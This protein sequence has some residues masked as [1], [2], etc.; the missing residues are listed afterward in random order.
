[1]SPTHWPTRRAIRAPTTSGW[2]WSAR[3]EP[4]TSRSPCRSC[5]GSSPTTASPRSRGDTP[6]N[7][8]IRV[9]LQGDDA[10]LRDLFERSGMVEIVDT[11]PEV[12]VWSLPQDADGLPA[13]MRI[14]LADTHGPAIVALTDSHPSRWFD[15]ALALGV[16]E[17]V[18]LPQEPQSLGMAAAKARAMRSRRASMAAMAPGSAKGHRSAH[19]FTVFSTKGGSGKTVIATN[20]AV[21][22]ARQG[23]RTLLIDFDLHS[24]DDALVLGLSPRWTILDLVQSPGDLDGEKLAGFVTRHS[25]G[26]DL[27]QPLLAVARQSYDAVVIDTSSQFAPAVLLAIDHTDSLVL[28]GAS[29][30][31]TIKSLKIALE[32]LELL[33]MDVKDVR[34]LM[35][36]SG[37]RVG[38]DDRDVERTLRREIT[39]TLASD[40][41]IPISVN[42][43][44]PVVIDAPKS[45]VAKSFYDMARSLDAVVGSLR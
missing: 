24:G 8:L 32:T 23:K 43:G 4:P 11:T 2:H 39:Y 27:L 35:N 15:E 18:Y 10:E 45:R 20:L 41:A 25:S 19:I 44:Q 29:D 3:P 22:F 37:A 17:I 34:I 16:D 42:R 38:L 28:V 9:S 40:K 31:P 26:V 36:R 14:A 6:M 7:D 21:C 5:Q 30:V 12:L 13:E 1:S 33:E